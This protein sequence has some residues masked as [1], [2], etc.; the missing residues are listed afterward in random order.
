MLIGLAFT[1]HLSLLTSYL[2]PLTS[3][4]SPLTLCYFLYIAS[5][6]TLTEV[7]SMLPAGTTAELAS[8]PDQ[9][10]LKSLLPAAQTVASILVGRCSCDLVR[11]RLPD[12]RED[13]RYLRQRYRALQLPR[14]HV[15]E[16]LHRHRVRGRSGLAAPPHWPET[17]AHFVVEH[18]RNAGP[19]L[20]LLHFGSKDSLVLNLQEPNPTLSV[21]DVRL[22]HRGWLAE[23]QPTLV[24]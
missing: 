23:G 15:I 24:R 18:A 5:P 9:Q 4:L 13:E 8:Y 3:H 22:D 6:L 12:P 10:S 16:S 1:S 19:T 17:L 7:R 14:P 11:D 21:N 20:Y 2:S